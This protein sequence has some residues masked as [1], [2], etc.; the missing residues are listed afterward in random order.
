MEN[1]RKK[2]EAKLQNTMEGHSSRLEQ[3][4]N[5][6]SQNL[7]IK[8]KLTEKLENYYSNNTRPVKGISKN[9]LTPSKDQ[10]SESWALK[11]EKRCNKKEFTVYSKK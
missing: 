10:T 6:E 8:W 3:E 2:N 9:S 11:K 7:K 4:Q 1:L 5:R